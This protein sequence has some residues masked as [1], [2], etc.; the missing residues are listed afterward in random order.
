MLK[1]HEIQVLLKAGHSRAEVARLAGIS[2]RSVKRIAQEADVTHV[3]DAGARRTPA[4]GRPSVVQRFRKFVAAV[5]Q[6]EPAL[7]SV[8]VL[9]R[10]R[11]QGY[12]GGKT[13]FYAVVAE[14]RPKEVRP[15]AM[16]RNARPARISG[17]SLSRQRD[18]YGHSERASSLSRCSA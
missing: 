17:P 14:A 2:L 5:L 12:T 3:D 15:L 13:A 4:I 7:R 6:E 16:A 10:A 1:R 9:R 8:E 11:G 18:S